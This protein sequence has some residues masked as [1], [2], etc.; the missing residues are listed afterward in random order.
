MLEFYILIDKDP[1]MKTTTTT[2][3]SHNKSNTNLC[4][5]CK[6]PNE[7]TSKICFACEGELNLVN[8]PSKK[9]TKKQEKQLELEQQE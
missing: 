8:K 5:K 4:S 3:I 7:I 1:L 6:Y 2:N 9:I